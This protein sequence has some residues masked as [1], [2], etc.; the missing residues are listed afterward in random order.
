MHTRT[1]AK[2]LLLR[3]KKKKSAS[4][5]P[6]VWGGCEGVLRSFYAKRF[7]NMLGCFLPKIKDSRVLRDATPPAM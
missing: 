1:Q 3:D 6:A 4:P 2:N 5:P 7:S